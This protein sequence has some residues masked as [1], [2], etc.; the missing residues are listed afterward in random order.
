[1]ASFEDNLLF[2]FTEEETPSANVDFLS[3]PEN[4]VGGDLHSIRLQLYAKQRNLAQDVGPA[5]ANEHHPKIVKAS[6]SNSFSTGK[7][8][9]AKKVNNARKIS[10]EL[11]GL[12]ELK[13]EAKD[14][15]TDNLRSPNNDANQDSSSQA[16]SGRRISRRL[17]DSGLLRMVHR[18]SLQHEARQLQ[19]KRN[20]IYYDISLRFK[21]QNIYASRHSAPYLTSY[22]VYYIQFNSI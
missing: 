20:S 22:L 15:A 14:D 9:P 16:S 18:E 4:Y 17:S 11:R 3:K 10:L 6:Q 1:M 8:L 7:H 2:S 21:R 13:E 19:N 12:T 5:N